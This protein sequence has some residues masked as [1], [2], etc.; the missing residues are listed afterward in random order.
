MIMGVKWV[1][2]LVSIPGGTDVFSTLSSNKAL[3]D[4]IVTPRRFS[5]LCRILLFPGNAAKFLAR[6]ILIDTISSLSQRL[7]RAESKKS[8][9]RPSEND[10][11]FAGGSNDITARLVNLKLVSGR[12]KLQFQ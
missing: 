9:R 2:N 11:R 7:R 10:C 4:R 12:P 3:A 5:K 8:N 6:N 1:S